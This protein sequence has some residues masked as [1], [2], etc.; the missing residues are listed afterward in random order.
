MK[1]F[2]MSLAFSAALLIGQ[3][4]RA[5]IYAYSSSGSN[6]AQGWQGNLGLDFDVNTAIQVT[7][8]GVYDFNGSGFVSAGNRVQ[9]DI[10][11]RDTQSIVTPI[12]VFIP[13]TAY[14]IAPGG[15]DILQAITP[16]LLGVG[17]YSVVTF[18]FSST[19]PNSNTNGGV[20]TSGTDSGSGQISFVGGAR[21]D[22]NTETA[23][24]PT[25]IDSGPYNR[26]D[27]GT[28]AFVTATPEPG[29]Y[30][31]LGL[32]LSGLFVA[33]RRRRA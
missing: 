27:S 28:F 20:S 7:A 9:V 22:S 14:Q 6:P 25:T 31:L 12:A 8:L 11:N 26:Y 13:G 5:D 32:G 10:Y 3:A 4:A 21:Y 19:F 18:A 24:F 1:Y 15:H 29:F 2:R 16:T 30:G 23:D 33:V 17:H